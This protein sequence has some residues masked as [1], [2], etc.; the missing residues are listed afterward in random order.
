MSATTDIEQLPAVDCAPWCEDG[1]GHVTQWSPRD[2]VCY[3]PEH[4]VKLSR[5][6]LLLDEYNG[7]QIR[8]RDWVS[9]YLHRQGDGASTSIELAHNE[10]A[11]V[12]LSPAEAREIARHLLECA[13]TAEHTRE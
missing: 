3:G 13:D 11:G 2:Q 7:Q 9:V 6:P 10:V 1:D 12:T 5:M 4:R 8:Q